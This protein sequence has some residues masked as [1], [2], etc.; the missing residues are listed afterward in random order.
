MLEQRLLDQLHEGAGAAE[1]DVAR[2]E[3][4]HR[5][6]DLLGLDD[7]LRRIEVM[8]DFQ[9]AGMGLQERLELGVEDDGLPVAVGVE[10][11]DAARSLQ[12]ALDQRHH[13]RDA[14]A[15]AE[16]QERGIALAQHEAA[17]RRQDVDRAALLHRVVEPVGALA[18]GDP[19]DR[20]LRQPIGLGGAGQGIAAVE[21]AVGVG[22]AEGQELAGTVAVRLGQGGRN[23]EDEGAGVRRF[24]DDL[25]DA[26]L[27]IGHQKPVFRCPISGRTLLADC[28]S[29]RR[30]K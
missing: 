19:L 23:L 22:D 18:A 12:G 10:Q 24:L 8:D 28:A 5:R 27:I 16:Q 13:G 3:A 21:G 4:L 6:H 30:E 17:G 2:L 9:P 1:I 15:A 11:A 26:Q 25:G 20:D 29:V 14:A 7:A